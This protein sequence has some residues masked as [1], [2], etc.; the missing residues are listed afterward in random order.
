MS[1]VPVAKA[2]GGV[3]W[4]RVALFYGLALGGAIA[5]AAGVAALGIRGW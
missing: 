1:G 5:V 3:A 2:S 4:R